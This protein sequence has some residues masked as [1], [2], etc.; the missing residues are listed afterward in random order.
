M[1]DLVYR[2]GG[3]PVQ[4]LA[5]VGLEDVV[6]GVSR[7]VAGVVNGLLFHKLHGGELQGTD[8]NLKDAASGE[9]FEWADM[10]AKFAREAREEGFEEIAKLFEGVAAIEK[11]HEERFRRLLHNIEGKVVFSRDGECIWQCLKCGHVMIGK[12]APKNCPVCKHP[13]SYFQIKAENY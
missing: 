7:A 4:A 11:Q 12:E 3:E 10:Y 6:L 9:H 8:I 5:H 13:Q 1:S 2:A